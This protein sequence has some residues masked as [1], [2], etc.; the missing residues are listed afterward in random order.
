MFQS[1]QRQLIKHIIISR[2][3]YNDIKARSQVTY[4]HT[5][6]EEHRTFEKNFDRLGKFIMFKNVL[7]SDYVTKISQVCNLNV[8]V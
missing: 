1:K 5:K 8:H 3:F 7:I 2:F 6:V 4:L